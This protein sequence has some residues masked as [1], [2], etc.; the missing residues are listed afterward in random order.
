MYSAVVHYPREGAAA[1]AEIWYAQARA[2]LTARDLDQQ[3][4]GCSGVR[5][6]PLSILPSGDLEVRAPRDIPIGYWYAT[7]YKKSVHE[8]C[9]LNSWY[10]RGV[11]A[12]VRDAISPILR[13][14]T[15]FAAILGPN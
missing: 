11:R 15:L 8:K 5:M 13:Y 14:S 12:P 10:F 7:E 3:A 1:P 9:I 4:S 2:A 6:D